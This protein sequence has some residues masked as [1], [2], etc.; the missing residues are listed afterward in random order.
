[1]LPQM[2]SFHQT[3]D[4]LLLAMKELQI[5]RLLRQANI[6]KS[7]GVPVAALFQ[8]LFLLAFRG[9][10]LFRFLRF[11]HTE[12]TISKKAF[13]RFLGSP[14]FNWP[15]FLLLLAAKITKVFGTLTGS[16]RAKMLVLD[17]SVLPRHRTSP[18]NFSRGFTTMCPINI[19]V[20]STCWPS[21]GRM[22]SALFPWLLIC[23]PPRRSR[24]A[25]MKRSKE[26]TAG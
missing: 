9:K 8:A 2:D 17:D 19:C 16:S 24:T 3:S 25:S 26:L 13:Y 12:R 18:W 10:N 14:S 4:Q 6:R 15:H 21:V 11:E 5:G 1:M 23:S 22:V 20:A 7:C